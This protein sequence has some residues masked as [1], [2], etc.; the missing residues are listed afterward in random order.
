MNTSFIQTST[1][2]NLYSL[3]YLFGI[4]ILMK[5]CDRNIIYLVFYVFSYFSLRGKCQKPTNYRI[6]YYVALKALNNLRTQNE[7]ILNILSNIWEGIA[8]MQNYQNFHDLMA[9]SCQKHWNWYRHRNPE[10]PVMSLQTS[11]QK[12]TTN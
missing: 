6:I 12:L 8:W 7:V 9:F 1:V 2:R 11:L 5:I 4:H 10:P 3:C